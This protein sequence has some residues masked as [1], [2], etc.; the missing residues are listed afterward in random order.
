MLE[1]KIKSIE[2]GFLIEW[3]E[4]IATGEFTTRQRAIT[5]SDEQKGVEKLLYYIADYFS[6]EC[7][8]DKFS[9]NNLKISWNKK[10]HKI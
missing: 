1:L 9:K 8:Y 5:F 10:G 2:N 7:G 3:Q 4:E 6:Y